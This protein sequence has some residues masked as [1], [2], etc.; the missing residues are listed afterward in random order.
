MFHSELLA[1]GFEPRQ[2]RVEHIDLQGTPGQI[3][4]RPR[5]ATRRPGHEVA[6]APRPSI[7]LPLH[8]WVD[9]SM[10]MVRPHFRFSHFDN[11]FPEMLAQAV[12]TNDVLLSDEHSSNG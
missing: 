3:V 12:G 7:Q 1:I 5:I 4:A 8:R 10:W 11:P 9:P 6:L 2:C